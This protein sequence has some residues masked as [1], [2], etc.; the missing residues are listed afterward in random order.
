MTLT[1]TW[2]PVF[3]SKKSGGR[4]VGVVVGLWMVIIGSR[5]VVVGLWCHGGPAARRC[6]VAVTRRGVEVVVV[7]WWCGDVV[8]V[9]RQRLRVATT[10]DTVHRLVA[11]SPM[12]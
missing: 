4:D 10:N 6:R 11:T 3:V 1:T 2:H 5:I 8:V 9:S 12:Q 7:S